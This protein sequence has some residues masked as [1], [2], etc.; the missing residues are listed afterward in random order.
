MT[1]KERMLRCVTRRMELLLC[2]FPAGYPPTT[3]ERLCDYSTAVI[4]EELNTISHISCV[5]ARAI[6]DKLN[7]DGIIQQCRITELSK[8]I[9]DK[10]A[11]DDV[12][13]VA[14]DGEAHKQ[15]N[16]HLHTFL[17]KRDWDGIEPVSYTHL[18]LPTNREV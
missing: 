1:P 9:V 11:V 16:L 5:D 14:T 7:D 4:E 17:T 3:L 18:T 2:C 13:E 15:V 6:M 8:L 12:T 10:T